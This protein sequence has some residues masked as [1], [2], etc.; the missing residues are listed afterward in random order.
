MSKTGNEFV[1]VQ[2][3]EVPG[4]SAERTGLGAV[5]CVVPGFFREN[6]G[7]AMQYA[8]DRLPPRKKN[9]GPSFRGLASKT[10]DAH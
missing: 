1:C 6:L 5:F 2:C 4:G 7:F 10:T 9:Q 8:G 3:W